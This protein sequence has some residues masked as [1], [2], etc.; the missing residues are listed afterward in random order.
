M[1]VRKGSRTKAR[2]RAID[3]LFETDER[4]A[5]VRPSDIRNTLD[6]RREVSAAQTPLPAYAIEIVEGV[7]AHLDEIDD[8]IES[9]SSRNWRRMPSVDRSI[10]RMA[11]WEILFNDDV[12]DVISI[13]EA[14][15]ISDSLSAPDSPAFIN[16]VLDRVKNTHREKRESDG[17]YLDLAAS[18]ADDTETLSGSIDAAYVDEYLD[19]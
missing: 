18:E 5:G 2:I 12:D 8:M 1:S 11:I 15:G 10:L 17:E 7:A 16:A 4:H 9:Y 19:D 6:Q 14:V 3:V 13:T